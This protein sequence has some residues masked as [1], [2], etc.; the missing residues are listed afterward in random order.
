MN[1][2]GPVVHVIPSGW[3][4]TCECIRIEIDLA[5]IFDVIEG[6]RAAVLFLVQLL[7]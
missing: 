1:G 7:A 4:G 3:K 2:T 5:R 6:V